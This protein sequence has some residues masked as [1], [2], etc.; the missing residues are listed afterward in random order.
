MR[1]KTHNDF[2]LEV[3]KINPDIEVLGFYVNS[4]TKIKVR[5]KN[6]N[7][8]WDAFPS[9]LV[10]GVRC[11]KCVCE[12]RSKAYTTPLI[13]MLK[14]VYA[15]H[16]DDIM[17]L[18]GYTR[19]KKK[20]KWY[21]RVCWNVWDALP[22]HIINDGIGC[23]KCSYEKMAL[24]KTTSLL[25]VLKQVFK[26]Y[27]DSIIYLE[28]YKNKTT[29]CKWYC[30]ICGNVWET[31]PEILLHAAKGCPICARKSRHIELCEI[32]RR[33][34][35]VHGDAI[36]YIGGYVDM[37]TKC[38]WK[39]NRCGYVWEAIPDNVLNGT[40][41]PICVKSSLEKPILE[42]LHKKGIK[43][44][45]DTGL[46]GSNYNGSSRPLRVD[47][48]I[49]TLKG[50]LAIEADGIQH[51]NNSYNVEQLK[52][53]QARDRYKDKILKERGYILIRVT[54]SPTKEWGFKNHI[55]LKEL[56]NLIEIGI[57]SKTGEI[58][59]ELFK[60]YDFNRE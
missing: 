43:P 45:H 58:D 4:Y 36:E 59:F 41:C 17:Y 12:E 16:G 9:A 2:I 5:C 7:R 15:I 24:N 49:E 31:T 22:L 13:D 14:Q 39:C 34:K 37:K 50:K 27:G 44:L 11:Q 40:G 48:I 54:S 28:G 35:E 3:S 56:L 51:F 42:A 1:K 18:E 25:E 60:Q 10:H 52:V 33:L 47:F 20:C 21:C 29:K 57:D 38:K 8:I 6:C 55:T 26:K 46:E 30:Q 19:K 23:P 32:L 53:Q